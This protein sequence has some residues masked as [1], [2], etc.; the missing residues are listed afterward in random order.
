MVLLYNFPPLAS[1]INSFMK[2]H[3]TNLV[4]T[5]VGNLG[6]SP[7]F[8]LSALFCTYREIGSGGAE[9]RIGE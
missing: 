7:N 5:N 3:I 9:T 6:P 1:I 4:G 8:E 2:V